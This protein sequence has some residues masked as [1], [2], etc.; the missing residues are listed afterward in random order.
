MLVREH[1]PLI[2]YAVIW[3]VSSR[4]CVWKGKHFLTSSSLTPSN[5]LVSHRNFTLLTGVATCRPGCLRADAGKFRSFHS[6]SSMAP[7]I[8]QLQKPQRIPN[9]EVPYV[10]NYT[11]LTTKINP[12]FDSKDIFCRPFAVGMLRC[13]QSEALICCKGSWLKLYFMYVHQ[14]LRVRRWLKKQLWLPIFIGSIISAH[15]P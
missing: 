15:R 11:F 5:C 13:S 3:W 1:G 10:E 9:S 6:S 4:R 12:L 14:V 8:T 2:P 7:Q